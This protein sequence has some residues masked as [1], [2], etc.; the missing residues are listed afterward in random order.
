MR[1]AHEKV[2]LSIF[3]SLRLNPRNDLSN[4]CSGTHPAPSAAPPSSPSGHSVLSASAAD[5]ASALASDVMLLAGGTVASGELLF[6]AS[7]APH[8]VPMLTA[9]PEQPQ[10]PSP[11]PHK[12]PVGFGWQTGLA[13]Q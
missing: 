8:P 12:V 10:T 1:D 2:L 6:A 9:L 13:E 5:E 11:P 7:A 4:S 3:T